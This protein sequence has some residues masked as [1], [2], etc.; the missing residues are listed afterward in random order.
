MYTCLQTVEKELVEFFNYM[1]T[2][3]LQEDDLGHM[4]AFLLSDVED[5]E[6][7]MSHAP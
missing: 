2:D 3:L 4:Q 1:I 5:E 7:A 6:S